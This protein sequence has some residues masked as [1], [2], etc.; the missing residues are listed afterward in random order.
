MGGGFLGVAAKILGHLTKKSRLIL[1]V[2]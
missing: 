1:E 2:G